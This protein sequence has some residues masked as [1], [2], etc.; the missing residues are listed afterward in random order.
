MGREEGSKIKGK[1]AVREKERKRKKKKDSEEKKKER[2]SSKVATA[3]E[4]E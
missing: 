1:K 4:T 2:N 3:G